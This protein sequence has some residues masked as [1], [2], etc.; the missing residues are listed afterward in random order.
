MYKILKLWLIE[1][2]QPKG[3]IYEKQY[4][5]ESIE[6][7]LAKLSDAIIWWDNSKWNQE[8]SWY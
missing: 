8:N 7:N 1:S 2:N 4:D 3:R 5:H 6:N